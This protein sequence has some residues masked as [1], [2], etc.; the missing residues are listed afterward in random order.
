[1]WGLDFK[2]ILPAAMILFAVVDITGSIPLIIDLRKKVGH[3]QS[4]KASIVSAII[5][6]AFVFVGESILHIIGIDVYSFAVAGAFV[7]FALA[8]EMVL[9]VEIF[10]DDVPASAAVFPLAF[11]LI[12]G[13]G[14][15]TTILS[16]RSEYAPVNIVVAIMLNILIVY[17]V[18]KLSEKIEKLI[19]P[20]GIT[21]IRKVFGVVL[22]AIAVKLF[23]SNI[24]VLLNQ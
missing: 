4:A 17:I 2:E 13:A 22:L 15:L 8:L 3:I 10:K 20:N 12:A 21:I 24:P 16:L 14:S 9:G 7:L 6:I 19:G 11:P 18:L 1:M 5:M 23:A